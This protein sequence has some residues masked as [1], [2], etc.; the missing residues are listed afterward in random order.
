VRAARRSCKKKVLTIEYVIYKVIATKFS[1]WT[2]GSQF[3]PHGS[4]SL[5]PSP[6]GLEDT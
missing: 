2:H 1:E 4:F 3:K 6:L 5:E